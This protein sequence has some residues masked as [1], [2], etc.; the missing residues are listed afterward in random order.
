VAIADAVATMRRGGAAVIDMSAGRAA[1]HTPDYVCRAAADALLA[2]NTH[3]TMSRGA[4][5]YRRACALKLERDNGIVADPEREIIATMGVKQGLMLALL[6]TLDP[7]DE[8]LI[9]DPCFVSYRSVIQL[10]G[11]VPVAV[12]LEAA[13]GF[14]WSRQDLEARVS[15]KTRAILLNSP[16]NPTGIVHTPED[17][18]AIAAVARAHDLIV[19][20]DEVYESVTWDGRKHHCIAALPD[21]RA[22]TIT[23]M[24][25]TKTFSMGGWRVG[26]V[27]APAP[28]LDAMVTLQQYLLTCANS[29]VQVGAAHALTESREEISSLWRDWEL[30]CK[31]VT[32]Q[33]N[34]M[35]G[36][37]CPMP[38]G[39]FYAWADITGTGLTSAEITHVLLNEQQIAV[40]PGSA[41]GARGEGYIRLTCVRSWD[42]LLEAMRRIQAAIGLVAARP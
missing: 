23:V 30:R 22:R 41:F 39:G 9:E 26:F 15:A 34:A 11:G 35:P 10:A 40:V 18:E 31:F 28:M 5:A 32:S 20:T 8:V 13:R 19:I 3:Q 25:L 2:G 14:R 33:L 21:M 7:G 36:I 24:G 4:T 16:H 38:E 29:F 37:V 27:F 42:D 6:A 1:E 17:L 12:P